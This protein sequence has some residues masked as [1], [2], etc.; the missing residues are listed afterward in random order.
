MN[1]AQFFM[2]MLLTAS[3]MFATEQW[4]APG[5]PIVPPTLPAVGNADAA[6]SVEPLVPRPNTRSCVVELFSR[7]EF[8]GAVPHAI[9]FQPPADCPGP[10]ARVVLENDLDVNAGIQYDRSAR[11]ELGGVNLYTG[12]TMEPRKNLS[13]RWHVERDVTDYSTLFAS[14]ASGSATLENY[15]DAVHDSRFHWRARLIFYA[16]DG[17]NPAPRFPDIVMPIAPKPVEISRAAPMIERIVTWPRNVERMAIDVLTM[18]QKSDEM[19]QHCVPNT[20][21]PSEVQSQDSCGY[22]FRESEVRID[23]I[24]AGF[25]PVYPWVFTGGM[26]AWNWTLIPGIGTLDLQPY[27]VDLT[28]FAA[29]MN[30]GQPHRIAVSVRGAGDYM[31]TTATLLAWRDA[32]RAVVTGGILRNTLEP[33][34]LTVTGKITLPG[35]KGVPVDIVA[36]RRGGVAGYV[37]G[38]HGRVTT[39]IDQSMRSTVRRTQHGNEADT[40]LLTHVDTRTV[41]SGGG[42]DRR[43]RRVEQFPLEW[44]VAT[45]PTSTR[46]TFSD[47]DQSLI[48]DETITGAAGTRRR[49]IRQTVSPRTLPDE[50]TTLYP[51]MVQSTV[52]IHI[53]D[54]VAG[55]YDRTVS[56]LAQSVTAVRDGCR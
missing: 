16:A 38:S 47:L 1:L 48:R 34:A 28:P 36:R 23:G 53:S 11:L 35:V 40:R 46:R 27:R 3:P 12:T 37:N 41:I 30:D 39:R 10:W 8:T 52:S 7:R 4:V 9:S 22:P 44:G 17:A 50:K 2:T 24:L 32:G 51:E 42:R 20:V 33:A 14:A 19:W 6:I 45:D 49:V 43:E 25:A 26:G 13:L 5:T 55:C 15:L 29:Q 31:A 21:L 18:P 56:V 54:S